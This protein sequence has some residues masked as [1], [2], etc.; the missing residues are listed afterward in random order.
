MLS[1][2]CPENIAARPPRARARDPHFPGCG[3]GIALGRSAMLSG[4]CPE[5]IA[6]RPP[7]AARAG[8]PFSWVTALA[9]PPGRCRDA[10][11]TVPRK[12]RCT[13]PAR[14][15]RGTPVFLGDGAGLAL[16]RSAPT[17][18]TPN[19]PE[20]AGVVPGSSFSGGNVV[21]EREGG[22]F[23]GGAGE[24][25]DGADVVAEDDT[26]DV[27]RNV[28]VEDDDREPLSMHSVIAVVSMTFRPSAARRRSSTWRNASRR[29]LHGIRGVDAVDFGGLEDRLRAHLDGA[30]AAVVSVVKYGLP[31]PAA[32]MTTRPFSRW[33]I[34]RRRM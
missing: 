34:A 2:R 9:G 21:S 18:D 31:V 25:D 33:R 24:A 23:L 22:Q 4:R 1:G 10:F 16:G 32:K 17:R 5:N 3:A 30:Q 19:F 12:H 14:C 29:V 20:T 26:A 15:A 6:A 13:P 11:G 7:R 8:P 28:H 27:A